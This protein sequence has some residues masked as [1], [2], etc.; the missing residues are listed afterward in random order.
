[1]SGVEAVDDVASA[2]ARGAKRRP[3]D[4]FASGLA[5][6]QRQQLQRRILEASGAAPFRH[7]LDTLGVDLTRGTLRLP[8][9]A[10]RGRLLLSMDRVAGLTSDAP[11]PSR[12]AGAPASRSSR[13]TPGQDSV[14]AA[15]SGSSRATLPPG[16]RAVASLTEQLHS[17]LRLRAQRE[18]AV[19][20]P[21]PV[22]WAVSD[23]IQLAKALGYTAFQFRRP[24]RERVGGV[25]R[26]AALTPIAGGGGGASSRRSRHAAAAKR[27][28]GGV[29]NDEDGDDGED[30]GSDESDSILNETLPATMTPSGSAVGAAGPPRAGG[31]TSSSPLLVAEKVEFSTVGGEGPEAPPPRISAATPPPSCFGEEAA[32]PWIEQFADSVPPIP[33]VDA[34]DSAELLSNGPQ[35]AGGGGGRRGSMFHPTAA[36][37]CKR[38]TALGDALSRQAKLHGVAAP[39]GT[40]A[41]F[42]ELSKVQ[43][44]AGLGSRRPSV[45]VVSTLG[46]AM[47]AAQQAPGGEPSG[48][49]TAAST[50]RP[51]GP[52]ASSLPVELVGLR[53]R[54][55]PGSQQAATAATQLVRRRR[56]GSVTSVASSA[57]DVAV[58]A[59]DPTDRGGLTAQEALLA[60]ASSRRDAPHAVATH[61]AARGCDA[62]STRP[63]VDGSMYAVVGVV[64]I[65][66]AR[67]ATVNDADHKAGGSSPSSLLQFVE[68]PSSQS[69]RAMNIPLHAGG[70][71]GAPLAAADAQAMASMWASRGILTFAT[72]D[73]VPPSEGQQRH[74][75]GGASVITCGSF[76]SAL[77]AASARMWQGPE[78]DA[79]GPRHLI[80]YLRCLA[81]DGDIPG[82]ASDVSSVPPLGGR[83]P[84]S[85]L[86]ARD[87]SLAPNTETPGLAA[88][89]PSTLRPVDISDLVENIVS[90]AGPSLSSPEHLQQ[91]AAQQHVDVAFVTVI[92]DATVIAVRRIATPTMLTAGTQGVAAPSSAAQTDV[93]MELR[94]VGSAGSLRSYAI[95]RPPP[96]LATTPARLMA[97]GGAYLVRSTASTHQGLFTFYLLKA[98]QEAFGASPR[99][100]TPTADAK[101]SPRASNSQGVSATT[102]LADVS[103]Y[104]TQQLSRRLLPDVSI[105]SLGWR[106]R[107]TSPPAFGGAPD[108]TAVG[109]AWVMASASP[110]RL[111]SPPSKTVSRRS[112]PLG[113]GSVPHR[114]DDAGSGGTQRGTNEASVAMMMIEA[115]CARCHPGALPFA[116]VRV[117]ADGVDPFFTRGARK[118]LSALSRRDACRAVIT[119]SVRATYRRNPRSLLTAIWRRMQED[120]CLVNQQPLQRNGDLNALRLQ[121]YLL[122]PTGAAVVELRHGGATSRHHGGTVAA[123]DDVSV[124]KACCLLYVRSAVSCHN[125]VPTPVSDIQDLLDLTPL[126]VAV[127]M[128][129]HAVTAEPMPSV[130]CSSLLCGLP[131]RTSARATST[132]PSLYEARASDFQD[133]WIDD[134]VRSLATVGSPTGG[135]PRRRGSFRRQLT[136][137]LSTAATATPVT[138]STGES[139]PAS[140]IAEVWEEITFVLS[141]SAFHLHRLAKH[142]RLGTFEIPSCHGMRVHAVEVVSR[143]ATDYAFDAALLVQARFRGW[144]ARKHLR[145][146][147]R[148]AI[149]LVRKVHVLGANML[150]KLARLHEETQEPYYAQGLGAIERW[151]ERERAS[152]FAQEQQ[153]RAHLWQRILSDVL[154]VEEATRAN[155]ELADVGARMLLSLESLCEAAL[156]GEAMVERH[157]L[158]SW[159]SVAWQACRGRSRIVG[160]EFGTRLQLRESAAE[161]RRQAAEADAVQA[162]R[163]SRKVVA[164]ARDF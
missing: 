38:G 140:S 155:L 30:G 89:P 142:A 109:R 55:V 82:A 19:A 149:G 108:R 41:L 154:F 97:Q 9:T 122:R 33:H 91:Q 57:A 70:R 126:S 150:S 29:M 42:Q 81:L 143:S 125:P 6:W 98:F 28:A 148:E 161:A 5:P 133:A 153:F 45:R 72:V 8:P 132:A 68:I 117:A 93:P 99:R 85:L 129:T 79:M 138:A 120:L 65:R 160:T 164:A 103:H 94:C 69:R 64:G 40:A 135:S 53:H 14:E 127:A 7:A 90:A 139:P 31:S 76:A 37:L 87:A 25:R 51:D 58:A 136:G 39:H 75:G 104:V 141:G 151:H 21:V 71:G 111:A 48:P 47:H 1:M 63:L 77:S 118:R 105:V 163:K 113:G 4:T 88:D 17:R 67:S 124:L 83:D 78:R 110:P 152:L 35:M 18:P 146:R 102:T 121:I 106:S 12:R 162:L 61:N 84:W 137:H 73:A 157:F 145:P 158:W 15:S 46:E 26:S 32:A 130:D 11:W 86:S 50:E 114:E 43:T 24:S 112:P 34:L 13:R 123:V 107:G 60:V 119:A 92:V 49:L 115:M 159:M 16:P 22:T 44:S 56:Q 96:H 59:L 2:A 23:G 95:S 128:D 62:A 36:P 52:A 147:M 66:S 100:S 101:R 144:L 131:L 134:Y 3:R 116:P 27:R 74:G 10:D 20:H 80:V 156:R 54:E